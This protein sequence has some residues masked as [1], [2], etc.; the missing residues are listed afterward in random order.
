M[1]SEEL[2]EKENKQ[3]LDELDLLEQS[4][5]KVS[6]GLKNISQQINILS[7]QLSSQKLNSGEIKVRTVEDHELTD[8][9]TKP[10]NVRGSQKTIVKR[11]FRKAYLVACKK[12]QAIEKNE[13]AGS[14]SIQTQLVILNLLGRC[15]NII[16]FYGLTRIGQDDYV[17]FDW[18]EHGSLKEVYEQFNIP[19]HTKLRFIS[20][21]FEGLSFIF[22]SG[23]LHHDVRCKNILVTDN[24][25]LDVKITNFQILRGIKA[26]TTSFSGLVDYVRWLAPEKMRGSRYNNKC[27]IFS[28]GMLVWELINEKVPYKDMSVR[29]IQEHV[30]SKKREYLSTQKNS[31]TILLELT[32]LIKQ[33]WDDDPELRLSYPEIL[34]LLSNLVNTE[35]YRFELDH[36]YLDDSFLNNVIPFEDRIRAHREKRFK[37]AWKCFDEHANLELSWQNIGKV[38]IFCKGFKLYALKLK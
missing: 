13:T 14:R 5:S 36:F 12:I 6:D 7:E 38:I 35:R 34:K 3:I 28:F 10:G 37:E 18:A 2:R 16:T 15:P 1:I 22:N 11:I 30:T 17:V 24:P 25:V 19:L 4:V 29:E 26:E 33:T 9:E 21:I 23:I 27:E 31:N 32:K 8:P 20:N